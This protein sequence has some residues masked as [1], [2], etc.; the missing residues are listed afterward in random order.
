MFVPYMVPCQHY[1]FIYDTKASL[2]RLMQK[3][4]RDN[5]SLCD[6]EFQ[7]QDILQTL[8]ALLY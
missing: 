8:A 5:P 2:E 7:I 4:I 6:F 1:L 3:D